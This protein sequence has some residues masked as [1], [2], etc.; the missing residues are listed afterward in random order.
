V[1]V[2]VKS[3]S[4]PVAVFLVLED[5]AETVKKNVLHGTTPDKA[6]VLARTDKNSQEATLEA[7]VPAKKGFAVVLGDASKDTQVNL[8]ITGG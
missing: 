8:K 1:K 4:S 2:E 6:K 5:D 3:D 7:T